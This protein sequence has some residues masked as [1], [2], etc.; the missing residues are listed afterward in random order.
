MLTLPAWASSLTGF[1]LRRRC[2]SIGLKAAPIRSRRQL[3]QAMSGSRYLFG[4]WNVE[5]G[6]VLTVT[7]GP[8]V[9]W[10]EANFIVQE[11][12][13]ARVTPTGAGTV[14][15]RPPSLDGYY[16]ARSTVTATATPRPDSGYEFLHWGGSLRGHHGRASNPARWRT[17]RPDR[18]FEAVFTSRPVV[19][20]ESTADPF[21]VYI[22]GEFRF[23]PY[24]LIGDTDRAVQIGVD[25]T[26]SPPV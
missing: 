17:V 5:G 9:T 23:G 22:D 18:V 25:A 26:A 2:G 6:R 8:G 4:R 13:E 19:R 11:S 16:T 7:A 15:L 20:I 1:S 14:E 21:A 10:I 12:V 3:A 24:A